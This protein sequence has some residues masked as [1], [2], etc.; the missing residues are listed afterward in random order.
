MKTLQ[1]GDFTYSEF[2]DV[3]VYHLGSGYLDFT[4]EELQNFDLNHTQ[5]DSEI[6]GRGGRVIGKKKKS[7]ALTGS[8]ASGLIS[9]GLLKVQTGGDIKYGNFKVKKAEAKIVNGNTIV[10][11]HEALGEPGAEIGEIQLF[12]AGGYLRATFE[13]GVEAEGDKFSYNPATKTITLPDSEDIK[14]GMKAR[15]SYERAITG[16]R[17]ND[18]SDKFSEAREMWIHCFATDQCDNKY[19][20]D[21]HI[22]RADFKGDFDFS[23]GDDQTS[24][25]FSFDAL[26][27]FCNNGTLDNDLFETFVYTDDEL[28]NGGGV[29]GLTTHEDVFATEDEVK[30]VFS[31]D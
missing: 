8:G 5:E 22:F 17:I 11:D 1:I 16:T 10:I 19:Y 15:Y 2:T 6:K 28:E 21:I 29:G 20:A 24:H 30:G 14:N 4:L 25:N 7:K 13:Q 27:D 31:D 3:D 26:P 12:S 9:P 23:F 18:P